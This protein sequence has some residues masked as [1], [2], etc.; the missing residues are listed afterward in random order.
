M[1]GLPEEKL[2]RKQRKRAKHKK[3][4]Q[5][6]RE[7][8]EQYWKVTMG[9]LAWECYQKYGR[10][11]VACASDIPFSYVL[12]NVVTLPDQVKNFIFKYDPETSFLL[13]FF[14]DEDDEGRSGYSVQVVNFNDEKASPIITAVKGKEELS[15]KI[16]D[17]V[18]QD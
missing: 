3:Q 17:F 5:R 15:E 18:V 2:S 7:L 12:P 10:G 13:S 11:V 16:N 1:G 14:Y 4:K 8:R 6:K 9:D